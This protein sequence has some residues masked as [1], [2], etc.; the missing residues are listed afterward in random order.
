VA[1]VLKAPYFYYFLEITGGVQKPP[2]DYILRKTKIRKQSL[3][4]GLKKQRKKE[5][6]IQK[7]TRIIQRSL[8][9]L[10]LENRE[11]PRLL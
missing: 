8:S 2:T 10:F 11:T 4:R 6:K 3:Q 1:S 9:I 7:I 5:K